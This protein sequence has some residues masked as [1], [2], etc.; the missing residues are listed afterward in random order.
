MKTLYNHPSLGE[1][2]I[3][4]SSR[5]RRVSVSVRPS[6]VT[7]TL[8][9]RFSKDAGLAF[10][11]SKRDWIEDAKKRAEEKVKKT[12][13]IRPPFRTRQHELEV[14]SGEKAGFVIRGTVVRVVLPVGAGV[15]SPFAQEVIRKA[16]TEVLRKEAKTILPD[17]V[18][19]LALQC[20]FSYGK[21]SFRNSVSRWGSCS[22]RDDISLSVHLMTLPDV[23]V[24]YVIL[25]ELCHTVHKNHGAEFHE[26]LNRVTNGR[27]RELNRELKNYS[28]RW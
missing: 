1:I 4:R 27:H 6:G 3:N 22:G 20:G 7:L 9:P 24:D 13:V 23:L 11:E 21:L 26:L 8:P 25:H 10:V 5:A 14:I 15:E 19:E 16:L 17:R 28:T 12:L 2:T 18:S